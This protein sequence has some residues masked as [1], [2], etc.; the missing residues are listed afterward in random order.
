MEFRTLERLTCPLCGNDEVPVVLMTWDDRYGQPDTFPVRECA[1]CELMFLGLTVHPDDMPALYSKYYG[2]EIGGP[3]GGWQ[4]GTS[5]VARLAR[6]WDGNLN[7]GYTVR[8]GER[9]LDV[10]C[11]TGTVLRMCRLRGAKGEGVEIDPKGVAQV[12]QRGFV[13]WEG[14]VEHPDLPAQSFERVVLNQVLEH[15]VDPIRLLSGCARLLKP[16]G[17]I[18]VAA[19]HVNGALR[20]LFKARWISWHVPY[21]VN[22]FSRRALEIAARAA[23][24]V[25][26]SFTLRTPSNWLALQISLGAPERG[27]PNPRFKT[28]FPLWLRGLLAPAGRLADGIGLGEGFLAL[29]ERGEERRAP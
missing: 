1:R 14:T 24:L 28:S 27:R 29:L 26:R 4:M 13:C 9:V 5:A 21:H 2:R 15:D 19:P 17:Q 20:S 3:V 10:G 16:G 7:P 18:V 22:F 11:G 25:V 8:P 6:W 23:G 12:R